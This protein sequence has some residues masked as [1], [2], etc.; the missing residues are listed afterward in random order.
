MQ[1]REL[2]TDS[3]TE[4]SDRTKER[5]AGPNGKHPVIPQRE[6]FCSF[7]AKQQPCT[8]TIKNS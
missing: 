6:D 5:M 1:L 4:H 2:L 8:V 7:R 3:K